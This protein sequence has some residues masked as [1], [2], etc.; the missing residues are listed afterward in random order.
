MLLSVVIQRERC[1]CGLCLYIASHALK[2]TLA[3]VTFASLGS[4][5]FALHL[6][7][8]MN[9]ANCQRISSQ[10][11]QYPALWQRLPFYLSPFAASKLG[12]DQ[13]LKDRKARIQ[14]ALCMLHLYSA[15]NVLCYI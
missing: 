3:S 6:T 11:A 7:L 5:R 2:S 9:S 1:Y 4:K 13:S 12:G 10:P 15:A 14:S 8:I